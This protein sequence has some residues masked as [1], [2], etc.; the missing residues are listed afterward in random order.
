MKAMHI[1]AGAVASAA[2]LA[3]APVSAQDERCPRIAGTEM[4]APGPET[5]AGAES[6]IYKTVD[7]ADLRLHVLHPEGGSNGGAALVLFSGAGWMFNQ[8]ASALPHAKPLV[9]RGMTVILPDYRTYCRDGVNIVEEVED[10]KS[11][12]R[13]V[14]AHA[15]ELGVDPSRIAAS[16]GSAGGHL[17]LS[18]AM[19]PDVDAPGEDRGVSTRPDLLVLF[20]PCVDPT[21]EIERQYSGA[22]IGDRG[23]EVSAR[24]H[25]TSGLPPTIIFQGTADPLYDGVRAYCAEARAAGNSCEFV[26]YEGADHGFFNPAN[27]TEWSEDAA[28]GMDAFLTKAGYLPPAE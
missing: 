9:A 17:A 25:M 5:L 14:R 8:V 28:A 10:A 11:A 19:F 7:G 4:V 27:P 6:H 20:Y 22:A 23:A 1:L 12:M 15:A 24:L 26:E 13:W 2:A 16:G 21:S 3:A 18:T